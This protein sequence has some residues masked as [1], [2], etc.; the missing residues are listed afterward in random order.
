MEKEKILKLL[1]DEDSKQLIL[2]ELTQTNVPEIIQEMIELF[3]AE[4][5]EIRGE[6][7]STLFLNEMT[8]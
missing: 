7:F 8:F 2:S 3:N 6:V 5:I 4:Q 1:R